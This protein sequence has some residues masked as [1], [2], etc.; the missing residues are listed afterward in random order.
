MLVYNEGDSDSNARIC[1]C[2]CSAGPMVSSFKN[3]EQ[4]ERV[5]QGFFCLRI[6]LR[7]KASFMG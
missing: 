4:L 1:W 3:S 2:L 7:L 6:I 5:I